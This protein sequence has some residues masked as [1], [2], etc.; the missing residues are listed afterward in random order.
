MIIDVR[1]KEEYAE[2]HAE[3]AVNVPLGDIMAGS[4]GALEGVARETPL[5]L[6]CRSG[7]R[8]ESARGL[9]QSMGFTSVVNLGGLA[10]ALRAL[11]S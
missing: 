1:T 10:D 9:L 2:G 11:G 7:A 3:G 8:S 6:Y 5:Q 4:L